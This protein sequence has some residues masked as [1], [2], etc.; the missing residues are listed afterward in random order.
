MLEVTTLLIETLKAKII[1]TYNPCEIYIFGS[2]AWG[3]PHNDS[4]LDVLI[5]VD[6]LTKDRDKLL[7]EGYLAL[8]NL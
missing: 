7:L 3:I 6:E 8:L 1:E 2:Y 5:V 4:D